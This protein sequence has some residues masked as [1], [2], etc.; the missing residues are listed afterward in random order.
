MDPEL[1]RRSSY[2]NR[3]KFQQPDQLTGPAPAC[4][5]DKER[6]AHQANPTRSKAWRQAD[7]PER[8]PP[9]F[10]EERGRS[11]SS[12]FDQVN[13]I[14]TKRDHTARREVTE[15]RRILRTGADQRK[16]LSVS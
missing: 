16:P 8:Q 5:T 11:A 4:P 14:C 12:P 1:Q 6:P 3:N 2:G 7:F 10:P 13:R 15:H 9:A